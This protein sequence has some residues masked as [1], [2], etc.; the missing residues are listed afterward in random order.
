MAAFDALSNT[1]E[2]KAT[3]LAAAVASAPSKNVA[4]GAGVTNPAPNT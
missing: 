1:L 2:A 4:P 3:A